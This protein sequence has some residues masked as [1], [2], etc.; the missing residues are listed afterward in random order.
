MNPDNTLTEGVKNEL[1][2]I[3]INLTNRTWWIEKTV[4]RE[5]LVYRTNEYTKNFWTINT[6]GRDIYNGT[7]IVKEVNN[8]QG[9]LLVEIMNFNS[10]LERQNQEKKSKRKKLILRTYMHFLIVKKEFLMLLKVEHFQ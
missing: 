1:N 7:I 4:D 2:K 9:S 10:K 3:E 5:S 8:D 6:F